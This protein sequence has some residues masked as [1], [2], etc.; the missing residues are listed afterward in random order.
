RQ[1]LGGVLLDAGRAGDAEAVYRADLARV[2]E[3]GWSLFGLARSLEAQQRQDDAARV[4]QRFERAWQRADITLASSRMIADDRAP[5]RAAASSIALAN[6]VALSYVQQG[7]PSG[8]AIVLLHGLTDSWRSFETMMP[9]LPRSFRVLAI[10][11][12]GH[13][14]SDRPADG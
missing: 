8:T 1:I 3:N 13:G 11:Q 12:R 14:D 9:K 2:R 4:R 6:G 7:D 5:R 10:S